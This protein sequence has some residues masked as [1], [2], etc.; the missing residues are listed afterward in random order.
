MFNTSA[1]SFAAHPFTRRKPGDCQPFWWGTRH[2]KWVSSLCSRPRKIRPNGMLPAP[3]RGPFIGV[4]QEVHADGG[5]G[6][7]VISFPSCRHLS[8]WCAREDVRLSLQ[9]LRTLRQQMARHIS[10][11]AE[12]ARIHSGLP[13][14]LFFLYVF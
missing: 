3:P 8:L 13:G 4:S 5:L 1:F 7:L 12:S 6:L 2:S 10:C 11:R 14:P 9:M